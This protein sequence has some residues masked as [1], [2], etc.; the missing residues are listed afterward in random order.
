MVFIYLPTF[1]V[2]L[3]TKFIYKNHLLVNCALVN[4]KSAHGRWVWLRF[5]WNRNGSFPVEVLFGVW[6]LSLISTT[7]YNI[8]NSVESGIKHQQSIYQSFFQSTASETVLLCLLA[9]RTRIVN[10]YKKENPE[11]NEVE[12]ISKLVGYCSTQVKDYVE[13]V[14]IPRIKNTMHQMSF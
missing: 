11:M 5:L 7:Y 13:I 14:Q 8:A 4:S 6:L 1:F 9:A 10:K 3:A 12:I 2:F